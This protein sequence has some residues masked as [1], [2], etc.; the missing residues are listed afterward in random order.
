M[1]TYKWNY[2]IKGKVFTNISVFHVLGNI[3]DTRDKRKSKLGLIPAI[4]EFY[5]LTGE[6]DFK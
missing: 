1:A 4:I 5:M 3:A 2:W 6:T